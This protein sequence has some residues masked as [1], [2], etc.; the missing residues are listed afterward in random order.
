MVIAFFCQTSCQTG[1]PL[2]QDI[3]DL[4]NSND[5]VWLAK[6]MSRLADFSQYQSNA[7]QQ[8]LGALFSK[9][10][11][12]PSSLT[13][14]THTANI[15]RPVPTMPGGGPP[16]MDPPEL[17][18][19]VILKML[20]REVLLTSSKLHALSYEQAI[21]ERK[22]RTLKSQLRQVCSPPP[23]LQRLLPA[24]SGDYRLT[25]QDIACH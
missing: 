3:R 2:L 8:R 7:L 18:D 5:R 11:L 23:P 10:G 22:L 20:Q 13:M 6:G 21:A 16:P 14:L 25:V 15:C 17:P 4:G 12:H 1:S 24:C 19:T 9:A